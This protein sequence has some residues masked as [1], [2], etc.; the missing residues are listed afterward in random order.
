VADEAYQVRTSVYHAGLALAAL[1]AAGWAWRSGG[2]SPLVGLVLSG[3]TNALIALEK[4][5]LLRRGRP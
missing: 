1:L 3:G 2:V 5:R 4:W